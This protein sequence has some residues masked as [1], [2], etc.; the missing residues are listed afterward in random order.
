M[1]NF[2]KVEIA[3]MQKGIFPNHSPSNL[4]AHFF[5]DAGN[6]YGA[7]WRLPPFPGGPNALMAQEPH[8]QREKEKVSS[9]SKQ[10][11]FTGPFCCG[12]LQLY[13][14]GQCKEEE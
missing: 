9:N 7:V 2:Y 14:V 3:K 10:E 13:N 5:G 12:T 8:S 6:F 1:K 4:G 11:H